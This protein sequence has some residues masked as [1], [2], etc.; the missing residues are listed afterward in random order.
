MRS[1]L[2]FVFLFLIGSARAEQPQRFLSLDLCQDWMLAYFS[3]PSAVIGLSPLHRVYPSDLINLP[4]GHWPSHK[5]SL[6]QIVSLAPSTIF[7]GQYNALQLRSRLIQLGFQVTVFDHPTSLD[8]I[9]TY[10]Q[11]FL[12]ALGLPL[13]R[14]VPKPE[15]KFPS[16]NQRLLI[17]GVNA[18]G[19]GKGTLED[20]LLTYAGWDNYITESGFI[21]LSL[22][23]LILDPPDAILFSAPDSR[24][25]ANQFSQHPV[26]KKV[27]VENNWIES[28]YWRWMCPGPWTWELIESLANIKLESHHYEDSQ[29]TF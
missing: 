19:T 26:L 11:D 17:L 27:V 9:E 7:V 20:E 23:A 21:T 25:L 12:Q 3:T 6:E 16:R 13:S 24:A 28:D 8:T 18:I 4:Q 15:K 29:S 5:G 2:V 1:I 22:E 10:Q 14:L